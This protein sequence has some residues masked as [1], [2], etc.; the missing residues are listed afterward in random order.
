MTHSHFFKIPS[1]TLQSVSLK[2]CLSI[3]PL[4]NNLI[5]FC[6]EG[7]MKQN[8]KAPTAHLRPVFERQADLCKALAHP[9]RLEILELLGTQEMS[10]SQ[11]CDI[12]EIPKA[13]ASQHVQILRDAGLVRVEKI[14]TSNLL[15]L[16]M[17]GIKEACTT[18]RNLLMSQLIQEKDQQTEL[19]DILKNDLKNKKGK[20][21]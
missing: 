18:V 11:L 14:S 12:L 1:L 5:F 2:V 8:P 4:T 19:R 10:S 15:S 7:R 20:T 16:T 6:P 3:C 17:P 21:K 9:V 13:N